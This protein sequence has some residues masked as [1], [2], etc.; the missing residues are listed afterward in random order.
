MI[1]I[2]E[3]EQCESLILKLELRIF[4]LTGAHMKWVLSVYYDVVV[5]IRYS[6]FCRPECWLLLANRVYAFNIWRDYYLA[7]RFKLSVVVNKST[8]HPSPTL[9]SKLKYVFLSVWC[10]SLVINIILSF[11]QCILVV[12]FAAHSSWG[13]CRKQRFLLYRMKNVKPR[14]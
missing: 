6:C 9:V 3:K 7:S 11:I 2:D 14:L 10:G 4:H 12:W 5:F 13:E 1:P 8:A